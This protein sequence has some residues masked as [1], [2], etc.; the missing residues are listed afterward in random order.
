LYPTVVS[1]AAAIGFS[2]VQGH[3]FVDGNKRMGH[4][5]MEVFLWLNG[6]EINASID[7]QERT[8]L[9][10]ASGALNRADFLGWLEGCVVPR[11]GTV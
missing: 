8:V 5:T 6:F 11:S 4:A 3:A 2:L 7:E 1:K 9:A 10:L